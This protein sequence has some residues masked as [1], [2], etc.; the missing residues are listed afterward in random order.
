MQKLLTYLL[1]RLKN[2]VSISYLNELLSNLILLTY[3]VF[4]R[5]LHPVY[6]QLFS[7]K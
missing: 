7:T 1:S 3:S 2:E 6:Y 4:F 5:F